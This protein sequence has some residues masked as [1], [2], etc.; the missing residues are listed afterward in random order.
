MGFGCVWKLTHEGILSGQQKEHCNSD[1]RANRLA[2]WVRHAEGE[3]VRKVF[4][5]RTE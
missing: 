2:L 1:P 4:K 3:K 5:E